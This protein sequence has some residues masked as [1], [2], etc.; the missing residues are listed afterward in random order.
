MSVNKIQ[1]QGS[2][3]YIE[4]NQPVINVSLS[5]TVTV[6]GVHKKGKLLIPTGAWTTVPTDG[7][8]D[9]KYFCVKNVGTGSLHVF[10]SN[11]GSANTVAK[12][13]DYTSSCV[14]AW[15]GSLTLYARA[16]DTA[17]YLDYSIFNKT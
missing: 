9:V 11:T 10:Q 17:S 16:Y 8:T 5:D 14:A 15:S 4:N 7:L 13:N 6:P 12:L 1:I 3:Q 2:F